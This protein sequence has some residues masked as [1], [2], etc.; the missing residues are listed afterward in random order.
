MPN[1]AEKFL[2][3]KQLIQAKTA[4]LEKFYQLKGRLDLILSQVFE[5]NFFFA[6][7]KNF[8]ICEFFPRLNWTI[9]KTRQNYR[10]QNRN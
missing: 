1:S 4:S 8:N 2:P 7:V 9:H 10:L 3:L 5:M 6:K